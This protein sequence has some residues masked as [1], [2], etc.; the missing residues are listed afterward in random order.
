[1]N[2]LNAASFLKKQDFPTQSVDKN[3]QRRNEKT[4]HILAH[5]GMARGIAYH[6]L[7]QMKKPTSSTD[8]STN[9]DKKLMEPDGKAN[10]HNG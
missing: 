2:N 6:Q 10:S 3:N 7:K 5:F 8:V 4:A 9:G 1:M